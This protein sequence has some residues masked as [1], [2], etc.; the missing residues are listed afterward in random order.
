M[1]GIIPDN[2]LTKSLFYF[3]YIASQWQDNVHLMVSNALGKP[4]NLINV[5]T[6]RIGG[7]YGGKAR[8][9]GL[10]SKND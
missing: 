4:Q 6:R 2:L 8:I 3:H 7:A 10:F 9:T 5:H 1:L